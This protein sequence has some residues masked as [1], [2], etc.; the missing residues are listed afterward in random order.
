[1]WKGGALDVKIGEIFGKWNVIEQGHDSRHVICKCAC[2]TI[3]E[4]R[5]D[6]LI[7]GRSKSCGCSKKE[8]HPWI[9]KGRQY[10]KELNHVYGC[11]IARCYNQKADSYIRYGGRGITVCPEW[12]SS[13]DSFAEW[14]YENGYVKGLTVDR[15][16]N[17][18]GYSP[19]NC[20][21]AT[22]QEQCH[23]K[24]NNVVLMIDGERYTATQAARKAGVKPSQVFG[25]LYRG[26]PKDEVIRRLRAVK[27]E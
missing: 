13:F 22:K 19:S 23:N 27:W 25:W 20:R 1:M 17:D 5:T 7:D 8:N 10:R 12:K 14:A 4:V 3:R 24:R 21:L 26:I 9:Y 16:D 15:I 18:S 6:H 11:M 2:G